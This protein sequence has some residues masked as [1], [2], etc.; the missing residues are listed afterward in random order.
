MYTLEY[1]HRVL[2]V[3]Y[4]CSEGELRELPARPVSNVR[5]PYLDD[6]LKRLLLIKR[7]LIGLQCTAYI[8]DEMLLLEGEYHWVLFQHCVHFFDMFIFNALC[9]LSIKIH[10]VWVK[11][12]HVSAETRKQVSISAYFFKIKPFF[13][14]N[15]IQKIFL[16]IVKINYFRSDL[17]DVSA[18]TKPLV[19]IGFTQYRPLSEIE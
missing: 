5:S 2:Q 13:W 3:V 9:F 7:L 15:F 4:L 10:S 16:S 1:T 17:T 14:D 8:H 6:Q 19:C 11:V 18:K 12:T